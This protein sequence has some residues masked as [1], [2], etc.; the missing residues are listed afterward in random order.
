MKITITN[1]SL[2]PRWESLQTIIRESTGDE[3]A[4]LIRI[5]RDDNGCDYRKT[6]AYT[7]GVRMENDSMMPVMLTV[8]AS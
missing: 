8:E 2:T 5:S 4:N 6:G 1:A 7:L 3:S